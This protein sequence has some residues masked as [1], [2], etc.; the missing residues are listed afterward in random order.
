VL[1]QYRDV[2]VLELVPRQYRDFL[3]LELVPRQYRDFLVLELVPR[4]YRD[5]LVLGLVRRQYRDFPVLELLPRQY[6]DFLDIAN[7]LEVR[8][9]APMLK[10][11]I[12]TRFLPDLTLSKTAGVLY[13]A[14]TAYPARGINH[15]CVGGIR[16]VHLFSFLCFVFC[17]SS[18]R[19]LFSTL[20]VSQECPFLIALSFFR[21]R[22]FM[23]II[24]NMNHK[25][26]TISVDHINKIQYVWI[27]IDEQPYLWIII[28]KT[29]QSLLIRRFTTPP[30][31]LP[32]PFS[33]LKHLTIFTLLLL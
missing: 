16:V 15:G 28:D 17:F 4:Q 8:Y 9:I 33:Y 2:L 5:F 31:P 1:R 22:L 6:R 27:I 32:S 30:H 12:P 26:K 25:T 23:Q 10:T 13:E 21:K 14:G 19:I 29:K 3:V 7:L 11:L 20:T 24:I 18:F